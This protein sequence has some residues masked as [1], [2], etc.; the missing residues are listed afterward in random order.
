MLK[1]C[2]KEI[3]IMNHKKWFA[4]IFG[5]AGIGLTLLFPPNNYSQR[6]YTFFWNI[7][8]G[9]VDVEDMTVRLVIFAV[10]SGILFFIPEGK[11]VKKQKAEPIFIRLIFA[12]IMI[13]LGSIFLWWSDGDAWDIIESVVFIAIACTLIIDY[14]R[15][16]KQKEGQSLKMVVKKKKRLLLLV[17][18]FVFGVLLLVLL[19]IGTASDV[20]WDGGFPRNQFRIHVTDSNDVPLTSAKLRVVDKSN[21]SSYGFP[22][23]EFTE[24]SQPQA[25]G[26]GTIVVHHNGG[27]S[28]GGSYKLLFGFIRWPPSWSEVIPEYYFHISLKG[29]SKKSLRYGD[30][31]DYECILDSSPKVIRPVEVREGVIENLRFG[32]VEKTVVLQRE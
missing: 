5:I 27:I 25:D 31:L 32:I 19:A 2:D 24:D 15:C 20:Y 3:N 22:I 30:L 26:S 7:P 28:Y 8:K 16:K 12:G 10:F 1:W 23:E 13:L 29:Y 11:K 14:I 9:D 4:I 21:V 17:S 18:S 6:P